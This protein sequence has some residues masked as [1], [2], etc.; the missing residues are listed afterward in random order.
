MVVIGFLFGKHSKAIMSVFCSILSYT[1]CSAHSVLHFAPA[2]VH[3]PAAPEPE[4]PLLN[5]AEPS[6]GKPDETEAIYQVFLNHSQ[7]MVF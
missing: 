6:D 4:P 2:P 7:L 1:H 5:P 3:A